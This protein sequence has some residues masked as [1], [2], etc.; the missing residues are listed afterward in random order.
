MTDGDRA[1]RALIVDDDGGVR[2][3]LREALGS[4]GCEVQEAASGEAALDHLAAEHVD[5]GLVDVR[6]PGMDGIE[7][8]RRAKRL[9]PDLYIVIITGIPTLDV[10]LEAGRQGAEDFLPK[11]IE[12]AQLEL[13]LKQLPLPPLGRPDQREPLPGLVGTS[14]ALRNVYRAVRRVAPKDETVLIQGESGTGKELAARAIHFWSRRRKRSFVPVNCSAVAEG[15]LLNELFGHEAES[16][17]GANDRKSGLIEHADGGT[18]FLDEVGDEQA[19]LQ[20]ALLRFLEQRE[21][22]RLGS[23]EVIEVDVRVIAATNKHLE[24]AVSEGRFRKDL[25]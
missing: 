17:T 11:P 9:R 3:M 7:L 23:S 16:F 15:V 1:P 12:L 5:V 20:T 6:M 14:P 25:Y 8:T 21:V 18:L 24:R 13:I 19:A 10:A 2:T 22:R 4:L